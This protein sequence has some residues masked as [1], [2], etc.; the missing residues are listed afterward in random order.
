MIRYPNKSERNIILSLV[1]RFVFMAAGVHFWRMTGKDTIYCPLPL[2]HTAGGVVS[3][4]QAFLFGCT[5][6]IKPK[7]SASQFFPDCIKYK[8]T[9]RAVLKLFPIILRVVKGLQ[10]HT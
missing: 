1:P 10:A 3:V 8:A 9:V 4:G 5:V 2:Y 7:F 6:C